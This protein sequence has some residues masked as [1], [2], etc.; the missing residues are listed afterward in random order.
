MRGIWVAAGILICTASACGA[1]VSQRVKTKAAR[2]LACNEEQ[3]RIV[4]A[5]E[6]VYRI[7]GCGMVVGYQCSEAANMS[8]HCQQL[9]VSKVSDDEGAPKAEQGAAMAKSN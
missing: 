5:V 1:D 4:D 8:T 6:G 7:T 3:T 9:Y 2:D